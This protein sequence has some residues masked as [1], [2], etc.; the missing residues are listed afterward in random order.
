MDGTVR[1]GQRPTRN[2]PSARLAPSDRFCGRIGRGAG[3]AWL[4]LLDKFNQKQNNGGKHF[5]A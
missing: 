3:T 4:M 1:D 2:Q 5:A